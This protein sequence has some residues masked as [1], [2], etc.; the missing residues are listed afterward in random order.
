[1]RTALI[2]SGQARSISQVWE[3]H[4]WYLRKLPNPDVFV[5]V[6]E[7]LQAQDMLS[8]K[9]AFPTARFE[10]ETVIQ[11]EITEPEEETPF[12]SGYPRSTSKRGV[13]KQ[14]WALNR[15]W[16]FFL[17]KV[18]PLEYDIVV[19]MRPDVAFV[20]CDLPK[21]FSP[22]LKMCLTP[23]WDRWSGV[24]DRFAIMG[25]LAAHAYFRTWL[26]KDELWAAGCPLHPEQMVRESLERFGITPDDTL[27]AEFLTVRCPT[28][29]HPNGG[30]L[31]CAPSVI[32]IAD[33]ARRGR[34]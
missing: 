5:S 3:N 9:R 15:A 19:R 17:S 4:R 13:L 8:L 10:M 7:D 1:M 24:N 18:Q 31:P 32:D 22:H 34:A 29:E 23:W 6:A 21:D 20:R 12:R 33:Y 30:Y 14:L 16:E 27:A 25:P 26:R 28:P 2:Y 11:P